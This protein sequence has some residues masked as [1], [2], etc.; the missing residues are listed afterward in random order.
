MEALNVEVVCDGEDSS[1]TIVMK[2]VAK[3][4]KHNLMVRQWTPEITNE[5]DLI[6]FHYGGLLTEKNK[7]ALPYLD[8]PVKKIAGLRGYLTFKRWTVGFFLESTHLHDFIGKL[9]AV[10]C[11]SKELQKM[12]TNVRQD[13]PTFVCH[14]GV[15]TEAFKPSPLPEH[16][17]IGWAGNAFSGAKVFPN[18]TKLPFPKRTAGDGIGTYRKFEEMPKF[19]SGISVYVSTSTEE[20]SPV[21]PKEAAACGRPV[22]AVE[23]G[24]LFEWVPEEYLVS[25]WQELIPII[26]RFSEDRNLLEVET[27]RFRELSLRWDYHRVVREY[28]DMFECVYGVG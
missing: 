3:Y 21:P 2:Q 15:D 16:F 1:A 13:I 14:S 9:D 17:C 19:Y 8:A 5:T 18:F 12:F 23:V 22:A 24:D 7:Q 10:S 27:R 26:K 25:T 11:A 6:Y 4:S 20:G 28:D